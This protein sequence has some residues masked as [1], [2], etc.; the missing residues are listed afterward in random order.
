MASS[1]TY[2]AVDAVVSSNF[3][4]YSASVSRARESARPDG[5][6][7]A[8]PDSHSADPASERDLLLGGGRKA[9][10]PF[11]R[12]RPLW[13]ASNPRRSSVYVP[14]RHTFDDLSVVPRNHCSSA[15]AP[16]S[17]WPA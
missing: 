17:I 15:A 12:P 16:K 10:K 1:S 4:I 5:S 2:Q 11:Y 8:L 9:E 13:Y 6:R 3:S 14:F 7:F